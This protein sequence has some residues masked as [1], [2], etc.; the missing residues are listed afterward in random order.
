LCEKTT[1]PLDRF[2]SNGE[3][4]LRRKIF[5]L[6]LNNIA[7]HLDNVHIY[8]VLIK[9]AHINIT[10]LYEEVIIEVAN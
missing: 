4:R 2:S 8:M 1:K 5:L 10:F 6:S 7:C 9:T 3:F